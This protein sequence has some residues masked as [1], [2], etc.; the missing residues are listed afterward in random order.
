MLKA[1]TRISKEIDEKVDKYNQD[2][3][4]S[5]SIRYWFDHV[6][7]DEDTDV[8][9]KK[10][11]FLNANKELIPSVSQQELEHYKQIRANFEDSK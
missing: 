6:C 9:V 1:M 2:N 3:G 8:I 7:S 4:T 10:E 11:D 5:I